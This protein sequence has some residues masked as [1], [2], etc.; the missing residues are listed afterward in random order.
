MDLASFYALLSMVATVGSSTMSETTKNI[1]TMYISIYYAK[2]NAL[3]KA[4]SDSY[5]PNRA[6]IN[7]EDIISFFAP[8]IPKQ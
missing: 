6:I 8:S 7:W 2:I 4:I 5:L 1:Q 3:C